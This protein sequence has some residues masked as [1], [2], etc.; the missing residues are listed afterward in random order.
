MT[1]STSSSPTTTSLIVKVIHQHAVLTPI[2]VDSYRVEHS[3]YSSKFAEQCISSDGDGGGGCHVPRCLSCGEITDGDGG[4]GSSSGGP[5]KRNK[6]NKKNKKTKKNKKNAGGG[7]CGGGG[8]GGG[9]DV[10]DSSSVIGSKTRFYS[11]L[12]DLTRTHPCQAVDCTLQQ[13]IAAL[14]WMAHFHATFAGTTSSSATSTSG[15]AGRD[16]RDHGRELRGL[17][18]CGTYWTLERKRDM[19]PSMER[20]YELEV[21]KRLR[22]EH[23]ET[24]M[25]SGVLL[26]GKRLKNAAEAIHQRLQPNH[27]KNNGSWYTIVHGDLKGANIA[28]SGSEEGKEV[29]R[30]RGREETKW[31]KQQRTTFNGRAVVLVVKTWHIL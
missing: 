15:R 31:L 11:V 27:L 2:Q 10:D 5:R 16:G 19:L 14:T 20:T 3:F 28:F 8:G 17:W 6:K 25:S 1:S 18:S 26:L 13:A 24:T 7:A 29:E 30:E 9:G 23:D 12:T 22:K 21:R 4:S